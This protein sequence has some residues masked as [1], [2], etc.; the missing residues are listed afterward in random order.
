VKLLDLNPAWYSVITESAGSMVRREGMGLIFDCPCCVAAGKRVGER[1]ILSVPFANPIDGGP[2]AE[3]RKAFWQR[4]GTTFEDLTL[5]PSV[6]ASGF[7]HWHGW[8]QNGE[9]R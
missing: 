4:T 1:E 3:T 7:G 6:D 9:A 2:P 8:I 5:S